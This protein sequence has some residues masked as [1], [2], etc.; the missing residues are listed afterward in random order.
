M[1]LPVRAIY[2][3]VSWSY[4]R[5]SSHRRITWPW[6]SHAR[7]FNCSCVD[8]EV[9]FRETEKDSDL[10]LHDKLVQKKWSHSFVNPF[11]YLF[12]AIHINNVIFL[13]TYTQMYTQNSKR[14]EQIL[15]FEKVAVTLL[16]LIIQIATVTK[17]IIF[18][19]KK[20]ET[21]WKKLYCFGEFLRLFF[22]ILIFIRPASRYS[23]R[24]FSR[25]NFCQIFPRFRPRVKG[26]SK[27][28]N[29]S[30]VQFNGSVAYIRAHGLA[31]QYV[32]P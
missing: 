2:I 24:N 8:N 23:S 31:T 30:R 28:R 25:R 26:V 1:W 19:K 9:S 29:F 32:I 18:L 6:G 3:H 22:S 12:V 15:R 13:K 21:A 4:S 5:H 10:Y 17:N 14:W 7:N 20:K 27:S 11:L 16:L